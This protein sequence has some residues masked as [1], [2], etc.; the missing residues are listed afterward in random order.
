MKKG[1]KMTEAVSSDDGG[2]QRV[3]IDY[4]EGEIV[5]S[6]ESRKNPKVSFHASGE[7]HL[8][9][10]T[11]PG[12]SI[13]SIDK[14]EE[15]ANILFEPLTVFPLDKKEKKDVPIPFK[16][17]EDKP[18]VGQLFVLPSNIRSEWMMPMFIKGAVSQFNFIFGYRGLD[19]CQDFTLHL[20][21][22]TKAGGPWPPY[23]YVVMREYRPQS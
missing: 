15:I 23:N 11:F 17:E 10:S 21:L 7:V 18:L 6:P 12:K 14:G 2:G 8:V 3:R 19:G 22:Y 20:V 1:S 4:S 16:F 5:Y 13:N 9:E